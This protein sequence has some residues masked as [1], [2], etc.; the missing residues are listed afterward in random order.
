[1]LRLQGGVREAISKK[2]ARTRTG[3]K[4]EPDDSRVS[5]DIY[6]VPWDTTHPTPGLTCSREKTAGA[7]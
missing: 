2:G 5:I 4:N 3:T 7:L 6:Q 1:M